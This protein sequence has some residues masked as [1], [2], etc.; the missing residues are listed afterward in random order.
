MGTKRN[1]L[2]I[3]ELQEFANITVTDEAEAFDQI[4]Q[5]EELI[6]A[7][8]GYQ[9][10]HVC[11]IVQGQATDATGTTITD[12]S[13]DTP[14]FRDN[15]F[16]TFCI[17]EIVAG[18]GAGQSAV[19][20]GSNRDSRQITVSLAFNTTPDSTSIY[21][22]YQLGKF[23]RHCDFF[24]T[25]DTL[26]YYKSIPDAV[27]RATAAQVQFMI[28]MGEDFFSGDGSE[29]SGEHIGNYS[30]SQGG[31][32]AGQSAV[33]RMLAPKARVLLRGI[34]NR[35]GRLEAENPTRL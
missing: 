25:P 27:K 6:D 5:A 2:T 16:F 24:H 22:I 31:G 10:K 21:K 12:D 29:M 13:S 19:I 9:E 7:Y 33:V 20:S 1:Y 30:Y 32:Q 35:L 4:G 8:V 14:L 18:T 15:N 17:V 26:T 34:K 23:P 28:E 3:A 11:R